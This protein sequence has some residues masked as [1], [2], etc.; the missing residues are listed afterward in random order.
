MLNS[1]FRKDLF[2]DKVALITGGGT[3]IGLRTARE[4][5]QLGATVV[6]ASRK[7]SKLDTALEQL[8]ADGA[9][10]HTLLCNI[11][12][13]D[14]VAQCVQETVK[15]AGKIDYLVNN[16]GGQFP[17]PAE[18]INRK[19]W[20]AVIETNLTG[21]FFMS[22]EVF[23]QQFKAKGGAIVN[24]IAN[25]WNGFPMMSH[26]GAARAGVDNLTKS[27]SVEWGRFGVRVN[28]VAPGVIHSSGLD[29]YGPEFKPYVLSAGKN[30]QTNRLG[31]EAEVAAAII[32]LLS[33]ASSFITGET[34]KVDGAESLYSPIYP[35]VE[36][37]NLSAF[38]NERP[39]APEPQK[40]QPTIE[41]PVEK[42]ETLT[43]PQT[44]EA[45]LHTL[46]ARFLADKANGVS[47]IVHFKISGQG[48]GNYTVIIDQNQCQPLS[49]LHGEPQCVVETDAE[50]YVDMAL[51]KVQ[52]EFAFMAGK[53]M[54]S[55]ISTMMTFIT[56][57]KNIS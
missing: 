10:A 55:E 7:Q 45:I 11:R 57:F 33:P 44:V 17:S 40:T 37:Q 56:L 48:G 12:E 30:N 13:E 4:L 23:K 32:F 46:P 8:K 51:G 49:E 39:D 5:A 20:H 53:L 2:K 19:G 29:N 25:M 21:T 16:A 31:T 54:V 28:A 15:L 43:G 1:I 6:I 42:A 47:I 36:H 3:G 22:Q 34:L 26:T 52:P 18:F 41:I 24:V 9:K 50:T 27:L 38:P 14:S 35:P